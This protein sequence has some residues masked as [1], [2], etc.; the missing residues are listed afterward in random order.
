MGKKSVLAVAVEWESAPS[1]KVTDI[2]YGGASLLPQKLTDGQKAVKKRLGSLWKIPLKDWSTTLESGVMVA[3]H[4][5]R[6]PE[7]V[8]FPQ[9][10]PNIPCPQYILEVLE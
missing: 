6:Q 5:L 9:L 8:R 3:Q 7:G 2:T 1:M 4:G 10:R